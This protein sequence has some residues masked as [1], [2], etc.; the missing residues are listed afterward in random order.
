MG[1]LDGKVAIVTGAGR[2]RGIG[3]AS[4]V[5]LAR[6]GADLVITGTGR[7]PSTFPEDEKRIG[8]RDIESVAEQIQEA[9][10]RALPMVSDVT[11]SQHVRQLV[12]KT[13]ETFGHIDILVNNA[14]F[15]RGPDRVPL[16]ELDEALKRPPA[17]Q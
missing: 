9:G 2:L 16:V 5:A 13:M 4:A 1:I 11:N 10:R 14:A 17:G 15:A 12:E 3:R 7:D 6:E 8:W